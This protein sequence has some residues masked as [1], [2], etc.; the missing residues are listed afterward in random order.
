MGLWIQNRGGDDAAHSHGDDAGVLGGVVT[1]S[2]FER[3]S[4]RAVHV[5]VLWR[6]DHMVGRTLQSDTDEGRKPEE[7]KRGEERKE[8]GK[9]KEAGR[10]HH[11]SRKKVPRKQEDSRKVVERKQEGSRKEAERKQKGSRKEAGGK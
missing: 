11:G 9:D 7:S 8:R 6:G 4:K 3:R 1:A 10:E 2:H 5:D